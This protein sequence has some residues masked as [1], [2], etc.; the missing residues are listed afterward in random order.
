MPNNKDRATLRDVINYTPEQYFSDS[1]VVLIRNTFKDNPVLM[2]VLRK[3]F[4]P[5][6]SDPSLPIEEFSKDA[7]L[8]GVDWMSMPAEHV[9]AII[10][11][12]M[13]A[14]KF[15]MGGLIQLRMLAHG[16]V[17]SPLTAETRRAKDSL[18]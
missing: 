1:E 3:I 8:I 13:E 11:G 9:K 2:G 7:L 17:E 16:S 18:K 14:I 15:I 6:V 5:T 4:L 12:R 10:Q